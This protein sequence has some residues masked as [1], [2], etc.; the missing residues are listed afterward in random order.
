[1]NGVQNDL[2]IG[3]RFI[4]IIKPR[5]TL[6]QSLARTRVH[7]LWIA[8]FTDCQRSVDVNC[9]EPVA[10]HHQTTLVSCRSIRTDRRANCNTTMPDD[11]RGDEADATYVDVTILSAE[12]ESFRQVRAHD[13]A[14]EHCHLAPAFQQQHR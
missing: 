12:P 10:S 5:K 13:I 3:G 6:N 7:P 1:M 8:F 11:L 4:R 9:N 2:G 14:V